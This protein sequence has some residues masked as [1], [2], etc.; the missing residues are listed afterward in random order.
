MKKKL[1]IAIH[2]NLFWAGGIELICILISG[3]QNQT[4]INNL[5][6]NVLIPKNETIPIK[7]K[8]K[9]I[10]RSIR[11]LKNINKQ[12]LGLKQ[13]DVLEILNN[14]E[15]KVTVAYYENT[16]DGLTSCLK[17]IHA[18][19]I[20]PIASSLPKSFPVPWIGY[21]YDLQHKHLP[22]YFSNVDIKGRNDT[23]NTLLQNATS[24]LVTSESV[25]HDISM[26]FPNHKSKIFTM[27]FCPISPKK[28]SLPSIEAIRRKYSLPKKYFL[29]SN[30]LWIHKSHTTTIDALKIIHDNYN[31]KKIHIVCTGGTYD[32]RFPNLFTELKEKINRLN[33]TKHISFL[34]FIP[35]QDHTV[36]M[37]NTLAILQPT[38][39]E[40]TRGGLCVSNA[41]ALGKAAIISD[42]PVNKEIKEKDIYFFKKQNPNDL[43]QK[44]VTLLKSTN[45]S[46]SSEELRSKELIRKQN[47]GNSLINLIMYTMKNYP[48]SNYT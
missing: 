36:I 34:G 16:I 20:L 2:G 35:K 4:K 45:N 32:H 43:A 40:G 10:L 8:I 21:I 14:L 13:K 31:T 22:H 29:I 37:Q 9:N 5:Q 23:F 12:T 42:I 18:D 15:K 30:H 11:Y 27:P 46:L 47:L 33:L 48:E 19:I 25:N 17:E 24:L 44:M 1:T 3:L 7:E 6:I 26:F 38:L 41:I 39:F 28:E